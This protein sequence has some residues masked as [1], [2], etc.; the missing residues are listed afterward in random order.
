[1]TT[2]LPRRLEILRLARRFDLIILEDDPYY[3]L[4]YGDGPRPASYF[5]LDKLDM[6][7]SLPGFSP[8]DGVND[9]SNGGMQIDMRSGR[10]LRMDS[11]SKIISAGIRLGWVTGPNVLVKAIETHVSSIQCCIHLHEVL[12]ASILERIHGRS[13]L[14]A[15][16]DGRAETATDLG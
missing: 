8:V 9:R 16:P 14:F 12:I 13:T 10:V 1:M 2:S 4:Y 6:T 15:H 11:F 3:F 5:A 7:A